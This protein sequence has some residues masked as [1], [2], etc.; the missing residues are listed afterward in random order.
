MSSALSLPIDELLKC[1]ESKSTVDYL[2]IDTR[3][4]GSVA[5]LGNVNTELSFKRRV[6]L[7]PLLGA[8]LKLSFTRSNRPQKNA[9][10]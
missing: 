8:G 2:G 5:L 10:W 1:R 9:L 4:F 6:S 7:K 3:L